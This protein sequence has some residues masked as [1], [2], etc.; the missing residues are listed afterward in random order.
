M[1]L[2]DSAR[3]VQVSG[4]YQGSIGAVS[5]L[6]RLDLHSTLEARIGG[7]T[8][9]L[10]LMAEIAGPTNYAPI[11]AIVLRDKDGFPYSMCT[12]EVSYVCPAISRTY[13]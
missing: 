11:Y 3:A 8:S 10:N 1:K 5:T 6:E 2:S 9:F 7:G 13:D 4:Q 12:P